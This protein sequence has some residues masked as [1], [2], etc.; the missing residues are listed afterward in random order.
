M[1]TPSATA[2]SGT[3]AT[4]EARLLVV[5]D[6]PNIRELLAAGLRYAGFDVVVASDGSEALRA[7]GYRT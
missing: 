3:A 7:A 1:S 4:S 5:D 6:E 2:G